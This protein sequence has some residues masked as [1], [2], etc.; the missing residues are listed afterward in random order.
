MTI[1]RHGW[2]GHIGPDA[3]ATCHIWEHWESNI[4]PHICS[5]PDCGASVDADHVRPICP[6]CKTAEK[7]INSDTCGSPKCEKF[8]GEYEMGLL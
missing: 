6:V 2:V 7:M 8:M 4:K 5:N 1:N 3:A